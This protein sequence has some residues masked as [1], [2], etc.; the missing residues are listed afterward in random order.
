MSLFPK[1]LGDANR[2]DLQVFPPSRFITCLMQLPVMPT[3]ERYGELIADFQTNA[4]QLGESKMMRVARLS[5]A[6][7]ARLG[8]D[9]L[10]MR[11]VTQPLGFGNGELALVN[12]AWS[13]IEPVGDKRWSQRGLFP[14]GRIVSQLVCH[15]GI[16]AATVVARRPWN[17]CCII[18]MKS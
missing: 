18:R 8:C 16:L 3:T 10:Q 4:T 1:I 12:R 9:K 14:V 13:R 17:R 2:I 5:T 11:L 6:D 7:Q 15:R